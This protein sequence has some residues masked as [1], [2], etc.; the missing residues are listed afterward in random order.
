MEQSRKSGSLFNSESEDKESF[1]SE[2]QE[3][4]KIVKKKYR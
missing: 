2:S 3:K 4:T 1:S